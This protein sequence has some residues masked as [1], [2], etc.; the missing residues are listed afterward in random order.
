MT[1]PEQNLSRV[2]RKKERKWSNNLLNILIAVVAIAIIIISLVIFTGGKD[3][4]DVTEKGLA[5]TEEREDDEKNQ[6]V[7]IKKKDDN[8]DDAKDV[9]GDS[10]ELPTD[11]VVDA[12]ESGVVTYASPDDKLIAETIINTAWEPIATKQTGNHVSLYDGKSVDWN[13]KQEALAYATGLSKDSMIFWKI[14][15]GGSPQQAIGIV[16]SPDKV[17][18]YRVYLEWIEEAGWKPV[19]MDVLTTLDFAY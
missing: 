10:N 2:N 5:A 9:E 8:S 7:D 13:E 6:D 3:S 19:K 17:E 16:S 18:K 1:E 15:N 14:K 11:E 12:D 4:G